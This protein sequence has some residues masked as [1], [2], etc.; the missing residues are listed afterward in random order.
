MLFD[1]LVAIRNGV[2][3]DVH[4]A[5]LLPVSLPVLLDVFR[6]AFGKVFRIV[7]GSGSLSVSQGDHAIERSI[8]HAEIA[9]AENVPEH[10]DKRVRVHLVPS[11]DAA[12]KAQRE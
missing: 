6:F 10:S 3:V 4:S 12:V 7:F 11:V 8:K 1:V 2:R 5:V 9:V